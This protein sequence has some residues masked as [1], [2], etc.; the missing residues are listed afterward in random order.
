MAVEI[1]ERPGKRAD[2]KKPK[3]F[4]RGALPV[5]RSIN[6][7]A[8]GQKPFN[9]KLAVPAVI[10]IVLAAVLFSKFAV[11]DR[12]AAVS[13][14]RQKLAVVQRQLD[15]GYA[16]IKSYDGLSETY[17]HYTYSG[18]TEEELGRAD[19]IEVLGLIERIVLPKAKVGSWSVTGNQLIMVITG[20]T[21]QDINV[22][23]QEL[24]EDE[25]VDFCTVTTAE[26][27]SENRAESE[28]SA[29]TAKV[30][31]YLNEA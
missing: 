4:G 8:V 11:A 18:M 27:K 14:A 16:E 2:Y 25:L 7:A 10:L 28:N 5:K 12:L 24:E 22:I 29:V 9:V 13:E 26:T 19:R 21:L 17:A 20:S 1:L 31:V 6:L 30:T 23:A 3:K 15:E